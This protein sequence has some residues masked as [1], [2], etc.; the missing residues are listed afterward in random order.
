MKFCFHDWGKWSEPIDTA[1][2]Y[3]KVQVRYCLNCNK[4]QIKK[5]KQP[6]NIWFNAAAI[7]EK[8]DKQ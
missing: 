5:V 4:A 8:K 7:K 3:T 2:C 1:G 6:W